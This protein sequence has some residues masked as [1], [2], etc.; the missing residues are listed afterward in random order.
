VKKTNEGKKLSP[1]EIWAARID[2]W[3]RARTREKGNLDSKEFWNGFDL[4]EEYEPFTRYPGKLI[5]PVLDHI[6]MH[7]SV[8]DIG[9][10]SGSI[11]MIVAKV[12]KTVTAVEPSSAQMER[13]RRKV[14]LEA[15]GNVSLVEQ[16]WEEVSIDE[17]G[18]HDIVIASYCLFMKDIEA[19]LQK[20]YDAA[21]KAV[22][23]VHLGSHDLRKAVRKI[24]GGDVTIPGLRLLMH[25][26]GDMGL[27]AEVR[28]FRREFEIPLELQLKM[29]KYAQGFSEA[30]LED[31]KNYCEKDGRLYVRRGRLWLRRVYRDALISILKGKDD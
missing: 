14:L 21:R 24:R 28:I 15:A 27:P 23:L 12:A 1:A 29:F 5:E 6:D 9:A 19:C 22:F 26:L 3:N 13:L 4:W 17:I 25:I 10:G 30:Q 7:S 16:R 18:C 20:M 11:S 8:L 2:Q 31:L